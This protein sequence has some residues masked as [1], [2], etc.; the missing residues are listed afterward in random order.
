[1]LSEEVETASNLGRT[2]STNTS[3]QQSR[4]PRHMAMGAAGAR[5][6][7]SVNSDISGTG[8]GAS[9]VEES[10][11]R[12]REKRQIAKAHLSQES[13]EDDE[14]GRGKRKRR[15]DE[16]EVRGH[17]SCLTGCRGHDAT[18]NNKRHLFLD[19]YSLF[20]NTAVVY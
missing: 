14:E 20:C 1:M 8:T 11:R 12:R 18:Y 16:Q 2:P 17:S 7:R 15:G 4:P 5:G 9:S 19:P 10:G 6:G 13:V 3:R